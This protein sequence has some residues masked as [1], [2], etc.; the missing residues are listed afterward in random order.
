[1]DDTNEHAKVDREKPMRT[2]LYAKKH[3]QLKKAENERG[4]LLWK[5]AHHLVSQHQMNTPEKQRGSIIRAEYFVFG[6]L[7]A[8]VSVCLYILRIPALILTKEKGDLL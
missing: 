2:Q 5:G 6:N 7:Y 4:G 3:R 1:M 8:C